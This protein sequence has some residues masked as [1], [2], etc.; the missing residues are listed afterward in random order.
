MFLYDRFISFLWL[1]LFPFYFLYF[2]FLLCF[3]HLDKEKVRKVNW[4]E[5]RGRIP[6]SFYGCQ[7]FSL[8]ELCILKLTVSTYS[9]CIGLD[10]LDLLLNCRTIFCLFHEASSKLIMGLEF[11]FG[12]SLEINTLLVYY[13]IV[14]CWKYHD[15]KLSNISLSIF[16][17]K[18]CFPGHLN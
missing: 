12:Y 9:L 10:L 5:V 15:L 4:G 18:P 17:W 2:F 6:L 11:C 14:S 16:P 8:W 3:V 1:D 7:V 13:L